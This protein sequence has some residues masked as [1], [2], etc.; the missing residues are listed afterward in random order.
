MGLR[1]LIT[2]FEGPEDEGSW[3]VGPLRP[4]SEAYLED[5]VLPRLEPVSREDYDAGFRGILQTGA[6]S[7]YVLDE[8]IVYWCV[9]F[10]PGLLVLRFDP[11][12]AVAGVAMRS[13]VPE[14]GGREPTPEDLRDYDEE[15]PNPQYRLIHDGWGAQFEAEERDAFRAA[16]GRVL[17]RF[18]RVVDQVDGEIDVD[19][20]E[21]E[22]EAQLARVIAWAGEGV[23]LPV[24]VLEELAELD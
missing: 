14:F 8:D 18:V 13:P 20:P 19:L 7:V 5:F 15:L 11:S 22:L 24:A 3:Y 16:S 21:E 6:R 2:V 1:Y 9:E 17:E 10:D 4:S 23:R 12:G